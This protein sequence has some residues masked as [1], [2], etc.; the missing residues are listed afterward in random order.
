MRSPN[1][2]RW[3]RHGGERMTAGSLERRGLGV[4]FG[5]NN[6]FALTAAGRAVLF[7]AFAHARL[8]RA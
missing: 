6:Y 8:G 1:G 2:H 3:C 4:I 7:R 5:G